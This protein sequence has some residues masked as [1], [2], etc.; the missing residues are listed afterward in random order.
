VTF[1][2][3]TS[4]VIRDGIVYAHADGELL[5]F[6]RNTYVGLQSRISALQQ[7]TKQLQDR[8]KKLKADANDS[9]RRRLDAGIASAQEQ[10]A[11]L[12]ADLPSTF[13]WRVPTDCPLTLILAGQR[14]FAGGE[15]KVAAYEID[16][17]R[18]VWSAPVTG[19]AYGLAAANDALL[20]ST[21]HGR[22]LC[23][24]TKKN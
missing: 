13:L 8:K 19:R 22:I 17:G 7:Q 12:Q 3:A 15:G 24:Q 10:I 11:A 18:E 14:L 4:I 20:V 23:L 21:D 9:E 2:R 6:D 16:A 5:A 1:P